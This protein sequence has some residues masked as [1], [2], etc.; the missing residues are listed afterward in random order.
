LNDSVLTLLL[1]LEK[2]RQ[3]SLLSTLAWHIEAPLMRLF[4]TQPPRGSPRRLNLGCGTVRAARWLN[5]DFATP[6][7]LVQRREWPD[8]SFDATRRWPCDDNYFEAIHTEHML[9]HFTYDASIDVLRECYRTLRPGGVMRAS[10]PDAAKL[11]DFYRN[12]PEVH[13]QFQDFGNGPAAISVLTQCHGHLS[14]W[15]GPTLATVFREV[16][17]VD[18]GER[19]CGESRF[20][21]A[22]DQPQRAWCSCYVEGVK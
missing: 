22:I 8:W 12:E 6:R 10:V 19:S 14:V 3:R 11:V 4:R 18:V 20:A 13:P 21:E 5:A 1:A 7:W 2:P 15:D 17:F 16:G 9:E